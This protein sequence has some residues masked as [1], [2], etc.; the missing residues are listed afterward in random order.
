MKN[1]WLKDSSRSNQWEG[2]NVGRISLLLLAMGCYAKTRN[3]IDEL[4]IA[5][6]KKKSPFTENTLGKILC[7]QCPDMDSHQQQ[8]VGKE[9]YRCSIEGQDGW[10][11][12]CKH[13]SLA[14]CFS[15]NHILDEP[16]DNNINHS[17]DDPEDDEDNKD[18]GGVFDFLFT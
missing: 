15:F 14:K 5:M 18:Y 12:F 8:I 6:R 16:D 17:N 10:D 13:F 9:E 7:K 2:T 11:K 1:I 3:G 4:F